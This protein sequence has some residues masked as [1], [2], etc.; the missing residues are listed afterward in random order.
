MRS[1][2]TMELIDG[3]GDF[4]RHALLLGGF[5]FGLGV[6]LA[7]HHVGSGDFGPRPDVVRL[8]GQHALQGKDAAGSLAGFKG[9]DAEQQVVGGVAGPVRLERLKEAIGLGPLP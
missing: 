9:R 4:G 8:Q 2:A 5:E 7:D 6:G 3:R 1:M